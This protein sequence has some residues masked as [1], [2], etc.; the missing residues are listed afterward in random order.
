[1]W[2]ET[3]G[4]QVGS[5]SR[6][7]CIEQAENGRLNEVND[8]EWFALKDFI[9]V[10]LDWLELYTKAHLLPASTGGFF[11]FRRSLLPRH[12]SLLKTMSIPSPDISHRAEI[13]LPSCHQRTMRAAQICYPIE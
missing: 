13:L 3:L 4:A 12:V 7:P 6:Q 1:M 2:Q 9:L 8:D 5:A 11:K 10:H